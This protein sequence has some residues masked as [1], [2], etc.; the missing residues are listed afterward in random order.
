M[1]DANPCLA[2]QDV[3]EFKKIY[4]NTCITDDLPIPKQTF[5]CV[6]IIKPADV[7]NGRDHADPTSVMAFKIRGVYETQE[8]ANERCKELAIIDPRFDIYVGEVGKWCPFDVEMTNVSN[9]KYMN[10][11]METLMENYKR[12]ELDKAEEILARKDN[13]KPSATVLTDQ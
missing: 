6:S 13:I 2:G 1:L 5:F 12:M 7:E 10:E 4:K 9:V 3:S 8:Q 11:K